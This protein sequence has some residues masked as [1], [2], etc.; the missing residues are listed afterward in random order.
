MVFGYPRYHPLED[1]SPGLTCPVLMVAGAND[2]VTPV[3]T[4]TKAAAAVGANATVKVLT[5]TH[6]T[7]YSQPDLTT[8]MLEFLE[9][10][11]PV[12]YATADKD[13]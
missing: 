4:I 13:R 8:E 9:Q 11:V 5:G 1:I 12:N 6:I 7:L 3:S 2:T 10:T